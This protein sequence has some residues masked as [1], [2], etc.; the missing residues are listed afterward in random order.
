MTYLPTLGWSALV[1]AAA[2]FLGNRWFFYLFGRAAAV[3]VVPWWEEACKALAAL[4]LPGALPVALHVGF[5]MVEFIYTAWRSE[6]DGA[7][8]GLLALSGHGLFGGLYVLTA[9][10]TGSW[11]TGYLVAGVSHTLFNFAVVRLVLPSLGAGAYA[12]SGKR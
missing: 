5:G 9:G 8:L 7:F 6:N 2:A 10:Q 12:G 11:W 1:A 4:Y 3:F